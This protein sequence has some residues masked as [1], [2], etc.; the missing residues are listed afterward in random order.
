[1]RR[2]LLAT[3]AIT[4]LSLAAAGPAGAQVLGV[5][6]GVNLSKIDYGGDFE[7]TTTAKP[8]AI[9]GAFIRLSP[10][11]FINLQ[12]EGLVTQHVVD[13]EGAS[14]NTL[15]FAEVPVHIRYGLFKGGSVRASAHGGATLGVL[16]MAK[17]RFAGET[18]DITDAFARW[19]VALSAGAEVEMNRWVFDVRYLFGVTD[20]Y[21]PE[22]AVDFP[23]RHRAVQIT[24]GYRF[25]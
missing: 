9:A 7:I 16:L 6:G 4:G 22:V 18:S 25:K 8:G 21:H 20:L 19:N 24:A 2:R 5:K 14:K 1:M 15:T 12:I 13:F 23:G 3:V 11:R 10:A 17:E